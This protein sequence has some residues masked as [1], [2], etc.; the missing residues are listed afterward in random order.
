[1]AHTLQVELVSP[2]QVHHTGEA[3]MVIARTTDGEIG[4]LP[5][6]ASLVAALAPGRVRILDLGGN[7]RVATVGPAFVEVHDDQVTIIADTIE[8]GGFPRPGT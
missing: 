5:G 3:S 7:E 2:E 6:H 1:M 8:A 4:F